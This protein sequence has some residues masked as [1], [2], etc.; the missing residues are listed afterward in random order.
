MSN[1]ENNPCGL[2]ASPYYRDTPSILFPRHMPGWRK[3]A[4]KT[5][6][7]LFNFKINMTFGSPGQH[8]TPVTSAMVR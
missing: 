2:D 6:Q 5:S 8:Y 1:E 4:Q 3:T 7:L